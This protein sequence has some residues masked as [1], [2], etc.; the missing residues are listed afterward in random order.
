LADDAR[1]FA[2]YDLYQR[3]VDLKI[4]GVS[5]DVFGFYK[6]V[7]ENYIYLKGLESDYYTTDRAPLADVV[8]IC[9][10]ASALVDAFHLSKTDFQEIEPGWH[11]L[12][13]R[14]LA[15]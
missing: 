11:V 13:R 12:A 6:Y 8:E 3:L 15:R 1:T 10:N 14:R 7:I 5:N 9:L 2:S 4:D